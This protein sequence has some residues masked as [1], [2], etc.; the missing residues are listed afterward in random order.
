MK[1]LYTGNYH[2]KQI[3]VFFRDILKTYQINNMEGSN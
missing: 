2:F 1:D 3:N